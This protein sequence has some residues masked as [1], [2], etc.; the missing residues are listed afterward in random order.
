MP[1]A[2]PTDPDHLLVLARNMRE[3][4]RLE[5]MD[6]SGSSP[7]VALEDGY[8][9]STKCLTILT[10]QDEVVG[11]FGV[12]PSPVDRLIGH[13]WMLATDLLDSIKVTFLRQSRK[14]LDD[15]AEGYPLL[16]N[17]CDKRN[18][19]H[20]KW[21]RWLGFSFIREIPE[22]GVGRVPFLEFVKIGDTHV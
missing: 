6:G 18:T 16:M 12:A 14:Y 5:L 2:I 8:I 10:D 19:V 11:V 4:D 13:P 15:L 21:L 17:C 20:I 7:L 3:A 22:Y 1:Y 9:H